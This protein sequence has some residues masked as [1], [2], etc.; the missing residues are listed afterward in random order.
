[1]IL[2]QPLTRLS[3][4]VCLGGVVGVVWVPELKNPTFDQRLQVSPP[5]EGTVRNLHVFKK[6]LESS[7]RGAQ[8]KYPHLDL[9]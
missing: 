8:H 7:R 4:E 2:K 5:K 6:I 9:G 1:V 3:E